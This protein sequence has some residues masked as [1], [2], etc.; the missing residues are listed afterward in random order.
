MGN[1]AP[2]AEP[3]RSSLF[4]EIYAVCCEN[5][6][7]VRALFTSDAQQ[8]AC[9]GNPRCASMLS[10]VTNRYTRKCTRMLV[11]FAVSMEVECMVV[12]LHQSMHFD[13]VLCSAISR[14]LNAQGMCGKTCGDTHT[15]RLYL[16]YLVRC[17]GEMWGQSPWWLDCEILC[18]GPSP[19]HQQC[20]RDALGRVC[21]QPRGLTPASTEKF[22]EP[23][24]SCGTNTI[25]DRCA[26][27]LQCAEHSLCL[28]VAGDTSCEC[29]TDSL[30]NSCADA[31]GVYRL[32]LTSKRLGM[33]PPYA[34]DCPVALI[35]LCR[36]D[37]EH[38][39]IEGRG[40]LPYFARIR[41][42]LQCLHRIP[43]KRIEQRGITHVL[44]VL[45]CNST[46][47]R[48]LTGDTLDIIGHVAGCFDTA[49]LRAQ[50][51]WCVLRCIRAN[52]GVRKDYSCQYAYQ[53][54]VGRAI[55]VCCSLCH[56]LFD[57]TDNCTTNRRCKMRA[58]HKK[59]RHRLSIALSGF[60]CSLVDITSFHESCREDICALAMYS[61]QQLHY[62]RTSS[63]SPVYSLM[64]AM[65]PL[66][67]QP[68]LPHQTMEVARYAQAV[69]TLCSAAVQGLLATY[70]GDLLH[71]IPQVQ[72]LLYRIPQKL[73]VLFYRTVFKR[74][75]R[76]VVRA[77]SKT[78][79]TEP[80][81]AI[82][83]TLLRVQV[84]W[85]PGILR[86]SHHFF[87]IMYLVS[88]GLPLLPTEA[89]SLSYD[90]LMLVTLCLQSIMQSD[91][92][93]PLLDKQLAVLSGV[94]HSTC[95]LV[96]AELNDQQLQVREFRVAFSF[97]CTCYS[98]HSPWTEVLRTVPQITMRILQY[99]HYF[100]I[101]VRSAL[102]QRYI[103]L[104]CILC[105]T[106]LLYPEVLTGVHEYAGCLV[107]C[108][109]TD[110]PD[111]VPS[112]QQYN[113]HQMLIGQIMLSSQ[114][115][116]ILHAQYT[117]T[118][119][120]V[121]TVELDALMDKTLYVLVALARVRK[122][123]C[124]Q[125]SFDDT[126]RTL[127]QVLELHPLYGVAEHAV[128]CYFRCEHIDST[129]FTCSLAERS[130]AVSSVV[131]ACVLELIQEL[132][133]DASVD[134]LHYNYHDHND[135][136][137]M[138]PSCTSGVVDVVDSTVSPQRRKKLQCVAQ[139]LHL[140]ELWPLHQKKRACF[141]TV[142]ALARVRGVVLSC[143]VG[144]ECGSAMGFVRIFMHYVQS[145][146]VLHCYPMLRDVA[147]FLEHVLC[148]EL[149]QCSSLSYSERAAVLLLRR[150]MLA[151]GYSVHASDSTTARQDCPLRVGETPQIVP[152]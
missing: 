43:M 138:P 108:S 16:M 41:M 147:S 127:L 69:I 18:T 112:L 130:Y 96:C 4:E 12:Y 115:L 34:L 119:S 9:D 146:V 150:V 2:G 28:L 91:A 88:L 36:R 11:D 46:P 137:P 13:P 72:A 132:T 149:L 129:A 100:Q 113:E 79:D 109:Y 120:T 90:S 92:V 61:I 133:I 50:A 51:L 78:A 128:S 126:S 65:L 63:V 73:P 95:V 74:V 104:L 8:G 24:C 145:N 59:Q 139:I 42:L 70:L 49:E 40:P 110:V 57:N 62:H 144:G 116:R 29:I 26:W 53:Y 84:R 121:G 31:L 44:G 56:K 99:I 33:Q 103:L 134:R 20:S 45:R 122:V 80:L 54:I 5:E 23:E 10:H 86:K 81:L 152:K 47:P 52:L 6:E 35:Q 94:L 21:W 68:V 17:C 3:T 136:A 83:S 1:K 22:W 39:Y 67:Q 118:E 148:P 82:L 55:A 30:R 25:S 114:L 19:L 117:R 64:R 75:A 97:V 151:H 102:F 105:D 60:V 124:A 15:R 89:Q 58:H 27:C 123:A 76:A 131:E 38:L 107:A 37:I 106:H 135:R 77:Q 66:C 71:H 93:S 140:L 98:Y 87:E 32:F 7:F 142:V 14:K 141:L 101:P 143:L 85:D 111:G 125:E 48:T